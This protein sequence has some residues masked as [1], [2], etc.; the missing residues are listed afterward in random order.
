MASGIYEDEAADDL[1]GGD[2]C[3]DLAGVMAGDM[4]SSL[5]S[6]RILGD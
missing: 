6:L 2:S 3:G 1:S 4:Q 5:L